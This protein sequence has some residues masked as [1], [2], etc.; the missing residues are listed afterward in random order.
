[1]TPSVGNGGGGSIP[2]RLARALVLAAAVWWGGA[3][4]V[5]WRASRHPPG[6]PDRGDGTLGLLVLGYPADPS[7]RPS[8][9]Q[10]WRCDILMRT[11]AAHRG[12]VRVVFS[13]GPTRSRVSEAASLASYAVGTLGLDPSVVELE[14]SATTTA[15]NVQSGLPMLAGCD[16]I[17]IVSNALHAARGRHEVAVLAPEAVPR[18]VLADDYRFAE[19]P[20]HKAVFTWHEAIAGLWYWWYDAHP[21]LTP[22]EVSAPASTQ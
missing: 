3:E 5:Q 14:E 13:G 4:F 19:R 7:G 12:P 6:A 22:V 16:R 17:A 9:E 20:W 18:L 2:G 1:M 21:S 15:E 10:R 8:E 11:I